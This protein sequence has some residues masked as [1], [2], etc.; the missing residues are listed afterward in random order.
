MVDNE[1]YEDT[2]TF[3]FYIKV[4]DLQDRLNDFFVST[5]LAKEE[6]KSYFPRPLFTADV[7]GYGKE[8]DDCKW[9]A[10]KR[11]KD[12][13]KKCVVMLSEKTKTEIKIEKLGIFDI[14]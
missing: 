12:S 8:E 4:S 11:L 7:N 13:I 6:D 5:G 3:L 2:F 10:Q 9:D 1:E 14:L